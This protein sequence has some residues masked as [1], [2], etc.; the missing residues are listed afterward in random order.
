MTNKFLNAALEYIDLGMSVVILGKDSKEPITAHTPNG[1]KDATRSKS[2]VT[3]WWTLTPKCNI[4][5]V[6]GARS[7]GIVVIDI[8][9]KHGVDGYETMRDWEMEHGDMPETV[10]C[11]TPT[12]GYHFYYRV[13]REIRPSTNDAIGVDIRG[14]DSYVVLPPSIH[15]DTKTE[16]VWENSP[17]ECEIA[18]ANELVY[19]FIDY[20]RPTENSKSESG[21]SNSDGVD[22]SGEVKEGNRNNKLFKMACGLMAQSWD[23]DAIIAAINTYNKM[24]CKPPYPQEK[25]DKLLKS[26]LSKPK[27]KSEQWYKEHIDNP[28]GNNGGETRGRP[29]KFNHAKVA[30]QLIAKNGACFV[31]GMPAI[32]SGKLYEIGWK[33]VSRE[34]IKIQEDAT[35]TNQKEVQHYLQVMAEQKRQSPPELIAFKNGVLNIHTMELRD[36]SDDDV[37]PNIIPHDWDADAECQT[38]DNVLLKMACGE[39]DI[40]ES[41]MEV[42]GVCMYRSS[43]FTQSAILLGEG[44]NGKSTYI[45]MLQALLGKENISS[46]DMSMLGKQFHTGQLAGK[47]ANLGDDISNEFQRG[48]LLSVFKK[49]VD[50]N[51][52]YAD[53]KGVEGFEFEPYA[54]LV[55]SANE[56]PRLADYTDGMLRRIFPIEFNAKFSKTDADYDPRIS[57][58]ITTKKACQ[59]M[60]VLGVMGLHQVIENNGFTP[61]AASSKRVEE[62]KA[63]NNTVLSW[64]LEN[65]W[66][67]ETLDGA[68]SITLYQ[69][70]RQW[71][72]E[73]GFQAVSRTKFSRQINKEFSMKTVD[74]WVN[75]ATKKVFHKA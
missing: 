30:K 61:N 12:G 4:G 56:F 8:D 65:Q 16:Y 17:D 24:K 63:D 23:D 50:G 7:S 73:S 58:K 53:V 43:E 39:S 3:D 55:F 48:D 1:L 45:R 33:A 44:S 27:G 46:L 14:D 32:R 5:M 21:T 71:C 62:I 31:D 75:G 67:T 22:A 29:R 54:T 68:V 41:L 69:Q 70:Y 37:I 36:Y 72:D 47:L 52:V 9:N 60:A 59:R 40:L 2:T 35:R 66:T 25:V 26:A 18:E 20:V 28:N 11:C 42:M 6:C 15:P 51:R 34:I 10:T 49:V 13:D 19:Q 38:V 74:E 64:A 57:R